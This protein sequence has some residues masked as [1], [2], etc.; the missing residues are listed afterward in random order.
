[1]ASTRSKNTP[2]NF[3]LE[4][5]E[6]INSLNYLLYPHSSYG[7]TYDTKLAGFGFNP[8]NMPASTLSKNY[9]CIESGLFGI[10]STNLVNPVDPIIPE[11]YHLNSTS[12]IKQTPVYIPSPLHIEPCQRPHFY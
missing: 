12:L 3:C 5:R 6:N 2:G 10:N 7:I 4:Q 9:I 11:C 1:M 8:G